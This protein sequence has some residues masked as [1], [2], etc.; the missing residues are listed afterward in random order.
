L[1]S[2][3]KEMEEIDKSL[4]QP[5]KSLSYSV[6]EA[7]QQ[8]SKSIIDQSVASSVEKQEKEDEIIVEQSRISKTLTA[9]TM[10]AI[11]IIILT[12]LFL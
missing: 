4:S 8:E 5:P 7:S 9:Q 3:E 6:N 12:L 10:Q 1:D 2:L 11:V